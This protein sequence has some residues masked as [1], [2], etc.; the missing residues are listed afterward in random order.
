MDNSLPI[1]PWI[2]VYLDNSLPIN[3]VIQLGSGPR[4]SY[5]HHIFCLRSFSTSALPVIL[6]SA[7]PDHHH[8][9][10]A[11]YLQPCLRKVTT[12]ILHLPVALDPRRCLRKVTTSTPIHHQFIQSICWLRPTASSTQ[13]DTAHLLQAQVLRLTQSSLRFVRHMGNAK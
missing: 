12:S 8:L 4:T 13:S 3:D 5:L 1:N 11:S 10:V 2:T 7:A 9:S 6:C